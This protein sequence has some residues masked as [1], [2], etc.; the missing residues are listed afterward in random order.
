MPAG[1]TT[2]GAVRLAA[3]RR[4]DMENS[5]FLSTSEWNAEINASYQE[6]FGLLTQKFGNDYFVAAPFA[7]LTDGTS[8]AYA[9]PTDFFKLLGV[10][11]QWPGSPTGWLTLTPFTF[12]ERNRYAIPN[13]Q[14]FLGATNLRYRLRGNYVLFA[15]VPAAGQT[16]RLWY[17]PRLAALSL[18]ADTLDG[19]NGWEEYIVVDAAR[20]ALEKEESYEGAQVQAGAKGALIAR[21]EAEA[22]NRDAT[23]LART[24]DV[25][26]GNDGAWAGPY[27]GGA[28][29]TG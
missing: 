19:V 1:V 9:L 25:R 7:I 3:Q 20:K 26:G 15:P 18:D 23:G 27:V 24:A 2:L 6:L 10:D 21:I 16:L 11:L 12:S 4:A 17:S 14:G 8:D 13:L 28:G 29:W 22:E 5:T